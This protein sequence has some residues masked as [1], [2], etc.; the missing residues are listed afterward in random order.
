MTR[1]GDETVVDW[2]DSDAA[3]D[4]PAYDRFGHISVAALQ[5]N[6]GVRMEHF[7]DFGMPALEGLD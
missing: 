4:E 6:A 2:Q 5:P 1:R 3:A 7:D